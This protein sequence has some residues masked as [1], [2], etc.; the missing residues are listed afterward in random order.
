MAAEEKPAMVAIH[1]TRYRA[2]C[3]ALGCGTVA[4]ATLRYADSRRQASAPGRELFCA[5][6]RSEER[7]PAEFAQNASSVWRERLDHPHIW[8]T[9]AR[10]RQWNHVNVIGT[11]RVMLRDP[12][13]QMTLVTPSDNAVDQMI[14]AAAAQIV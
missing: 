3:I 1:T 6:D 10:R 13:M 12:L 7:R 5:H 11:G 8:Q 2:K 14:A 4:R 9:I